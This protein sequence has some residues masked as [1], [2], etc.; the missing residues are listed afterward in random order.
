MFNIKMKTHQSNICLAKL[1]HY[2]FLLPVFLL[3]SNEKMF[4]MKLI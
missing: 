4:S 1:L 3:N 2:N